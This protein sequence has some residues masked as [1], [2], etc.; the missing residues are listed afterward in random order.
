MEQ[1]ASDDNPGRWYGT[2]GGDVSNGKNRLDCAD[3]VRF[4]SFGKDKSQS[5]KLAR[6]DR[7]IEEERR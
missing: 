5:T 2:V 1:S 6:R 3:E 4:K 7:K